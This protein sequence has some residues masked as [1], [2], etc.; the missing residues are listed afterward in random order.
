MKEDTFRAINICPDEAIG[1]QKK[2][3]EQ[4]RNNTNND[5]HERI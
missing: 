1:V 2:Y 5:M 3:I 4:I